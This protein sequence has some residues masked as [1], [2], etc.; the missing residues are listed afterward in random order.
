MLNMNQQD[1]RT[2]Y[3]HHYN[4]DKLYMEARYHTQV[5]VAVGISGI[6]Q[7]IQGLGRQQ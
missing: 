7:N 4:V 3:R 5:A 2:N 6:I 1:S